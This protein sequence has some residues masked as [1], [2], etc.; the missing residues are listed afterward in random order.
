MDPS[1]LHYALALLAAVLVGL[2]KTGFPG[3]ALP[4]VLLMA[5]AFPHDVRL[6]VGAIMPAILLGDVI[7]VSW[8]RRHAQWSRLLVL[9]PY[10]AAGMVPA[11]VVLALAD[12]NQLRPILGALVLGLFA[13][14]IARQLGGW[15]D[16][17]QQR[18]FAAG[19]GVAA[20]FGTMIGNAAGPI[21]SIYLISQGLR[22]EQFIGTAAWFFFVVNL[23]KVPV[24]AGLGMITP[25]TLAFGGLAAL[26][27]PLGS[28]L[29]I[30][31]LRQIPQR[32][33]N[34]CALGLAGLAALRLVLAR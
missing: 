8:Y 31:I 22:K 17:P 12:G 21:M 19:M 9:F 24:M 15:N 25:Q 33:F 30:W 26:A 27:V 4:S 18:W 3:A 6:S 20:G 7:A 16:V 32:P 29:G 5:E 28:A 34:L 14:E 2:S 11:V 1:L 23:S 13:L 10:V